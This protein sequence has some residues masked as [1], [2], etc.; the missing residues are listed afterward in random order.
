MQ[1]LKS[2]KKLL[3]MYC[4]KVLQKIDWGIIITDFSGKIGL[5][6]NIKNHNTMKEYMNQKEHLFLH[7]YC[8]EKWINSR[9][10]FAYGVEYVGLIP[11]DSPV[12]LINF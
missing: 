10:V 12:F 7:I 8:K 11:T 9:K 6:P 1:R 3:R 5:L 2:A 4:K